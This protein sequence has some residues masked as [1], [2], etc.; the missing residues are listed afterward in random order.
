MFLNP[1]QSLSQRDHTLAV[2]LQR[3]KPRAA[4]SPLIGRSPEHV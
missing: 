1:A 4:W 2:S 3:F